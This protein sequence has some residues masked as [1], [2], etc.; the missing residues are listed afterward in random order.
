[1]EKIR[2]F[3]IKIY[4]IL[5]VFSVLFLIGSTVASAI[6]WLAVNVFYP[7]SI[8]IEVTKY[9]FLILVPTTISAIMLQAYKKRLEREM[10]TL[11]EESNKIEPL[12]TNVTILSDKVK[13][14]EETISKI[15][16]LNAQ[17]KNLSEIQRQT[18]KNFSDR[19]QRIHENLQYLHNI[20]AIPCPN[21]NCKQWIKIPIP[22]SIVK[23]IHLVDGP[24][25]GKFGAGREMQVVCQ[26][27][28]EVYHIVYP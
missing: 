10:G 2:E 16:D 23:E 27:C 11:K 5:K 28:G 21:P 13:G 1:M 4:D 14:F 22:A 6:V 3:L 8:A 18:H 20:F 19:F 24:P 26:A 25:K 7:E 17:V 12:K 9:F 15:E